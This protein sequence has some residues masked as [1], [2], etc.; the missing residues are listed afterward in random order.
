MVSRIIEELG[1]ESVAVDVDPEWGIAPGISTPHHCYRFMPDRLKG[2]GFF[3]AVVRKEGE[4]KPFSPTL[5]PDSRKPKEKENPAGLRC[6][7]EAAG[8]IDSRWAEKSHS[9]PRTT[10]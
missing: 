9:M 1:A 3:V 10:A 5:R 4:W 8:W 2:E 6:Q 7:K